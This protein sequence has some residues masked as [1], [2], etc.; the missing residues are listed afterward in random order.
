M[1]DTIGTLC[2]FVTF[3]HPVVP[4]TTRMYFSVTRWTWPVR[5]TAGRPHGEASGFPLSH[6]LPDQTLP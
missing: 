3:Y 2:N 6:I 1:D 5:S 4:Q